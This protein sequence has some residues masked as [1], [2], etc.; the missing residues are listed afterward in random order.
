MNEQ[1]MTHLSN[2]LN[3]WGISPVV[4]GDLPSLRRDCVALKPND[5]YGNTRY[6]STPSLGEPLLEI[7]IRNSSYPVGQQQYSTISKAL[8]K[9]R[10][11]NVGIE[12]CLLVGSPGYLGSDAAGFGEW[13][14]VF[15]F[16][17]SER[18]E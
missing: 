14:L 1:V 2:L 15:H 18:S 8:D 3:S 12:S 17:I 11:P 10:D 16:T 5:G 4:V 6:F 13:H 9:Y 7:I